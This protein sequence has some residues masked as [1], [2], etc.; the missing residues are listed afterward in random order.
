MNQSDI[1]LLNEIT[2]A[3]EIN[4]HHS[5]DPVF[6][7]EQLDGMIGLIARVETPCKWAESPQFDDDAWMS[8]C[9]MTFVFYSDG[10]IE[11]NFKSCPKCGR[12]IIVNGGAG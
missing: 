9:G 7:Q 2:Q 4:V 12:Q 6:T 11:N 3:M 5:L 8:E 10:P 1:K